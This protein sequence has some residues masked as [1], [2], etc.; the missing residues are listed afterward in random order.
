MNR[1]PLWKYIVI[2]VALAIGVLYTLPNL[3]GETPAVQISSVKA[4][5][6]VDPSTLSRAEDALKA[7]NIAYNGAVFDNTGNNPSVRI[8]FSDTDTQL[9][10]KDL[11]QASLNTDATDPTYVVALNLLSASPEWLSRIHALPMYLG[12]DCAAGPTSCCKST[13]PALS[14][15]VWMPP[16][17]TPAHCC[18]TRTS[19]TTG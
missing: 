12:L 13:W 2:L 19:A 4:T 17:P 1:Y 7:Q 18:A 14:R 8:R 15:S 6:K 5:V 9:R 3:F 16:L 10:A 11:L